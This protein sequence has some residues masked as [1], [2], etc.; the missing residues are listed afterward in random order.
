MS[1]LCIC[2]YVCT[3]AL[4]VCVCVCVC[5]LRAYE[6]VSVRVS[7]TCVCVWSHWLLDSHDNSD[8]ISTLSPLSGHETTSLSVD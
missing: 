4:C 3:R 7:R 1:V 6:R 5:V 8:L 2:V